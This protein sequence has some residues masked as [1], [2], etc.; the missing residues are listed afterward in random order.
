MEPEGNDFKGF[1]A[2][3]QTDRKHCL[4]YEEYKDHV[5]S[6]SELW[7]RA[8]SV[9]DVGSFAPVDMELV[10]PLGQK[11]GG[12]DEGQL[13]LRFVRNGVVADTEQIHRPISSTPRSPAH[14]S[15]TGFT[16]ATP[17]PHQIWQGIE[18][19]WSTDL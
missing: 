12:G 4:E 19:V 18:G 2:L 5:R 10:E 11:D 16:A 1:L 6:T 9:H 3:Y 7:D 15:R 13:H 14:M 8:S 17:T